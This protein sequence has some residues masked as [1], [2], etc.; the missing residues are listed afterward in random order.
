MSEHIRM[1]ELVE[2]R[3][4]LGQ[5]MRALGMMNTP[6]DAEDQFRAIAQYRFAC[7]AWE[8]VEKEYREAISRLS[9]PELEA[10][11]DEY[12][13]HER[14]GNETDEQDVGQKRPSTD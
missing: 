14:N 5:R 1:K 4:R 3:Q 12:K 13:V 9:V 8:A 10:L 2:R 7:D 6:T 11:A